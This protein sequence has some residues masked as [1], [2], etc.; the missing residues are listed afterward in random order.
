MARTWRQQRGQQTARLVAEYLRPLAPGA[1]ATPSAYAG[2]DIRNVPWDVEV[3]A[4]REETWSHAVPG[5]DHLPDPGQMLCSQCVGV[6]HHNRFSLR[7]A[8]RQAARRRKPE[9]VLPPMVVLRPDGTGENSVGE[10]V[11]VRF[12][13]DDREILAEL[14]AA[15]AELEERRGKD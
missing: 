14:L 5:A 3:K 9:H 8:L 10:F 4:P 11:V 15:R 2:T 13:A 6:L 1:E 12:F 7:G